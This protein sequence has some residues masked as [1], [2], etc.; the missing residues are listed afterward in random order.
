MGKNSGGV[1]YKTSNKKSRTN[2][3]TRKIAAVISDLEGKGYSRI[4]PFPIGF[5]EGRM[6]KFAKSNDMN[7]LRGSIYMRVDEISHALRDSKA[8]KGLVITNQDLISFP[9]RMKGMDLYFDTKTKNFTYVDDH[10]KYIISAAKGK[11]IKAKNRKAS[12]FV[13]AQKLNNEELFKGVRF[14]KV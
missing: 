2:I 13:T 8:E 12:Y 3:A 1:R 6:I 10:A 5:V 14:M 9:K 4:E 11:K 7:I